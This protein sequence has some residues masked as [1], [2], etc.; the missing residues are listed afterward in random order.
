[1][2]NPSR[3]PPSQFSTEKCLPLLYLTLRV[4]PIGMRDPAGLAYLLAR[5]ADTIADTSLV[6][7]ELLL[8]A[9]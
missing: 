4:L 2:P 5:A 7:P 1:M 3:V 6:P 9:C 8:R